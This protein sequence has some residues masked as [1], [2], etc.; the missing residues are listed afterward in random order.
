MS[1]RPGHRLLPSLRLRG[2]TLIELLIV[3]AVI[4]SLLA[5]LMP[6]LRAAREQARKA[7]CGV[8]LGRLATAAH[9]YAGTYDGWIVGSPLS[10]GAWMFTDAGPGDN[11]N[12]DALGDTIELWDFVGPMLR[13]WGRPLRDPTILERWDRYRRLAE[14]RCPAN[15]YRAGFHFEPGEGGYDAGVGP[16]FSYNMSRNFLMAGVN[17]KHRFAHRMWL[18]GT[19]LPNLPP[20][21]R[22]DWHSER[23]PSGYL[24]RLDHIGDPAGKVCFADGSRYTTHEVGPDYHLLPYAKWGGAFA[25]VGPYARYS[26]SWDRFVG[27]VDPDRRSRYID[28]RLY[29]YRHGVRVRN[30]RLGEYAMNLAFFDGHVET[31]TDINSADPRIWM[32]RGTR[33]YVNEDAFPDIQRRYGYRAVVEIP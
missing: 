21:S 22:R 17:H 29:G 23:I 12:T 30:H 16:M 28:A 4:A 13:L 15:G 1:Q 11:S 14:F 10:S 2:F 25:D 9:E 20:L 7:A 19:G 31:R 32:P 33:Y 5:I 24:P 26:R 27:F 8:R 18:I 3:V 6:S